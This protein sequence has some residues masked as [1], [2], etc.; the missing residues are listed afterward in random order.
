M[1]KVSIKHTYITN[2]RPKSSFKNIPLNK[3]KRD[4]LILYCKNFFIFLLLLKNNNDTNFVKTNFFIKKNNQ[5]TVNSL[6]APYRHKLARHQFTITR[7]QINT[8]S[9]FLLDQKIKFF[10]QEEINFFCKNA[11][12]LKTLFETNIVY[13]HKISITFFFFF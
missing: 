1:N 7:Y 9:I 3:K 5:N 10:K 8:Q 11:L 12:K 2:F 4:N 13:Q 6:R